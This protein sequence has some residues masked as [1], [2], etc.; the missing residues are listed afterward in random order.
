MVLQIVNRFQHLRGGGEFLSQLLELKKIIRNLTIF[1]YFSLIN[2]SMAN[3]A[4]C[5]VI[6]INRSA[7]L[8]DFYVPQ[9][10]S[11]K[12]LTRCLR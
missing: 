11:A 10:Q 12:H 9:S 2:Y 8:G 4:K 3:R 1:K 6:Y 5:R 7:D